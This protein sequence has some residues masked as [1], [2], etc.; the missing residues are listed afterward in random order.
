ME[1][2]ARRTKDKIFKIKLR[3]RAMNRK[4]L[5][6]KIK[7]QSNAFGIRESS[8][9]ERGFFLSPSYDWVVELRPKPIWFTIVIRHFKEN[10]LSSST[11]HFD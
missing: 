5:H 10:M 9:E 11:H 7:I 8:G 4:Y 3:N 6:V 1:E 2:G